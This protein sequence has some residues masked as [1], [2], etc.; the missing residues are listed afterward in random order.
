MSNQL[1]GDTDA[2]GPGPHSQSLRAVID[3]AQV[4]SALRAHSFHRRKTESHGAKN[5]ERT[6]VWDEFWDDV[7]KENR[8]ITVE[9]IY[10]F[11]DELENNIWGNQYD[12][13]ME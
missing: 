10:E 5:A 12:I 9:D 2:S 7:C 13:P 11:R 1:L 6:K 3:L 8:N 4:P